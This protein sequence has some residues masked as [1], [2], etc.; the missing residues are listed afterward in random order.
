M[1]VLTVDY[2]AKGAD[3]RFAQSLHETGFAVIENHPIPWAK[4][5]Q[6]YR[7]WGAF[8]NDPIREA[9]AFD[10][11]TQDG[12]I[13]GK[14]SETAKGEKQKDLKEFYHLYFPWGR[15]PKTI[16]ENSRELFYLT[17]D[18]GKELLVWIE[19]HLPENIQKKLSMKLS[20]MVS[21]ERTLYRILHYP[22]FNG[23]EPAGAI[24]AA[25]H[26]DINLI[27]VLP[28]A[29]EAGLQAKD[30]D[31]NWH[32]VKTD[33]RTLVI[34]IGDM[35]QEATDRYYI[36]TTHRVI[37]PEGSNAKKAR[38]S[39]PLFIHPKANVKLSDRYPTAEGYLHERLVELGLRKGDAG[40]MA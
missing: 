15:Y 16:S 31:G 7:E 12:Y 13:S 9:Y 37:N 8:F 29:S 40:V 38:M 11:A 6:A 19:R 28:A 33:P 1:D 35:L 3:E 2:R 10:S 34:N 17:L 24:R 14:L 20:D 4:I 5:E 30:K 18:F 25:A 27:T 36:S 39:M 26:E 22:P 23:T 32:T 21:L